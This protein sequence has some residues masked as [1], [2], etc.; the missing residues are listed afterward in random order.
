[1]KSPWWYR[2]RT[3]VFAALF[4]AGFFIGAFVSVALHHTY[5]PAYRE[6]GHSFGANGPVWALAFAAVCA[7]IC[8]GL[9]VWG[10]SY[11]RAGIVWHADARTDEL[12]EL[13]VGLRPARRPRNQIFKRTL[14]DFGHP[15]P[16]AA[17]ANSP[18]PWQ[19]SHLTLYTSI[20]LA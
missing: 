17:P 20:S 3:W 18:M 19:S 8:Y 5:V 16:T 14:L 10:S 1:M 12:L 15:S 6:L 2:G 13:V 9:R 4:F 7:A 11:L